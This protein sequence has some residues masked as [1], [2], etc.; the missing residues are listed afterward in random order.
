[1]SDMNVQA[2]GYIDISQMF[3]ATV[4]GASSA[5]GPDSLMYLTPEALLTYVETQ[6]KSLDG[7]IRK[8]LD[9]QRDLIARKKLLGDIETAVAN[10]GGDKQA[11]TD[12]YQAAID[13]LPPGD[14]LRAELMKG[15][16]QASNMQ[17][18]G[19]MLMFVNDPEMLKKMTA[20]LNA[21][22]CKV[23]E[24]QV[25]N[26]TAD[27]NAASEINMIEVQSLMSQ[28]ATAVQ[29]STGMLQKLGAMAENIVGNI[30]R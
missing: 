22:I 4:T 10:G 19:G 13:A 30:G 9:G 14:P 16:G 7:D 8:R 21:D 25:K 26:V 24:T 15:L 12:A 28:R 5:K 20:A 1:M 29:L 2:K 6:L 17:A 18:A 23:L 3:G 11:I 27:L